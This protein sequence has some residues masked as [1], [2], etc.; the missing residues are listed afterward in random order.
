MKKQLVDWLTVIEVP[1]SPT[2]L[3]WDDYIEEIIA[4]PWR[5]EEPVADSLKVSL[6]TAENHYVMLVRPEGDNY[7]LTVYALPRRP[8]KDEQPFNEDSFIGGGEFSRETLHH[9]LYAILQRELVALI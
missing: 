2:V 8:F 4:Q 6:Y 3:R 1:P 9:C 7:S 5:S